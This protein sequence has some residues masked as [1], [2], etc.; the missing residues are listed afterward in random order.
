MNRI[1]ILRAS[2]EE[3]LEFARR[4]AAN[5]TPL[6]V[7]SGG[8]FSDAS[9]GL[10]DTPFPEGEPPFS[11]PCGIFRRRYAAIFLRNPEESG[12]VHCLIVSRRWGEEGGR[13]VWTYNKR[14]P[15]L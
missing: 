12:V 3:F 14:A 5:G 6:D 1:G 15:L 11:A 8:R 2:V 10:P 4:D 9:G 13:E 7:V